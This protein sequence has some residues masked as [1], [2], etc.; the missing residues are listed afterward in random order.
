MPEPDPVNQKN[1]LLA[2]LNFAV[3][4]KELLDRAAAFSG[5]PEIEAILQALNGK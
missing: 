4:K 2:Q 5:D 3:S 1:A